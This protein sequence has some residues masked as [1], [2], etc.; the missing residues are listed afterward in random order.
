[1]S[2]GIQQRPELT[3]RSRKI[4]YAVITEYIATGE[5]VGSR[6]LARRYGINLS[7]ATIRN[8]L[9]DLEEAGF[10][11]QPHTS[12][13]RV[14]TDMGFRV[15]VDALVQMREVTAD[16]RAA[17]VARM[18]TLR[19]GQD[20][21]A[22]ETG[23]LLASL[24]GAAALVAPPRPDQEQLAQLRFMPL[25]D[26]R[27]LAVMVTQSGDVQNRLV[28]WSDALDLK[29]LERVDNYLRELIGAG[30]TLT[31]IREALAQEMATE[32]DQYDELRRR[33]KVMIDA[34]AAGS[35]GRPG[36][37]IEGQGQ[38]FDRPEFSDAEKIRGYLRTFEERER[39]L[40]LL[41]RTIFAGGF[42]VLI[43]SEANLGDVQDISVVSASYGAGSSTGTLGVIGPT[44]MDYAKV[45]PL[46]GFTA[47][48]MSRVLEGGGEDEDPED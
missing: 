43:G 38:L 30:R 45:V 14:P 44:R 27:V 13:G 3:F 24:T 47:R 18:K 28:Q 12:A 19:P 29:E 16:D 4:L 20:D 42:Q 21:I 11:S 41:D 2:G 35:E 32:R 33:V 7:P 26:D 1:M 9:S 15:F 36:M 23:R 10:L 8:V 6:K 31:A 25:R 22:R 46:V 17:I 34:A 5:P 48:M 40:E 39:L 37:V